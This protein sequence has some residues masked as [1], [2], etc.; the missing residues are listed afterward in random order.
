MTGV[1]ITSLEQCRMEL[2]AARAEALAAETKL[3]GVRAAR[4]RDLTKQIADAIAYV[5]RLRFVVEAD[6][7]ARGF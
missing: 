2:R 5:E 6:S 7:A 4:A 3:S 1:A